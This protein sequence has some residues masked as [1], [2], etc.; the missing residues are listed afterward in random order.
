VKSAEVGQKMDGEAGEVK[1]EKLDTLSER[2]KTL[3]LTY[4]PHWRVSPWEKREKEAVVGAFLEDLEAYLLENRWSVQERGPESRTYRFE[5]DPRTFLKIRNYIDYFGVHTVYL[6][7]IR[8]VRERPG[9]W[10][11]VLAEGELVF[12]YLKRMS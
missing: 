3:R 2:Y 5:E 12:D 1:E 8:L 7:E 9:L 6:I 10:D 11:K 4:F